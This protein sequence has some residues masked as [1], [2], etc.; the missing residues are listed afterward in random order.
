MLR[1]IPDMLASYCDMLS[2]SPEARAEGLNC[3][4]PAGFADYPQARKPD[5]LI[6]V[7]APWYVGYFATW[8]D[9]AHHAPDDVRVL[10]YA[11]LLADPAAVLQTALRH[12]D[13]PRGRAACQAALDIAWRDRDT[14]RFNQGRAGRGTEYFSTAQ[15]QRL[16]RLLSYHPSL[17][18]WRGALA[19]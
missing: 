3:P 19:F 5:F 9:A 16:E 13:L 17:E 8:A 15:L 12:A 6:D 18:E 7:V 11:Q 10:R 1:P 4:I 14:L 2:A